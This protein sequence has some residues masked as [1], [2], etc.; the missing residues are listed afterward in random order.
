MSTTHAHC[1]VFS[2]VSAPWVSLKLGSGVSSET[3]AAA[4]GFLVV[5]LLLLAMRTKCPRKAPLLSLELSPSLH[6]FFLSEEKGPSCFH[7]E[8]VKCKKDFCEQGKN[9]IACLEQVLERY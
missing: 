8:G 1:F 4:I 2:F 6:V 3:G 9:S 7:G 5:T